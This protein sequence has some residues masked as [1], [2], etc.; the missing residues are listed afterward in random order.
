MEIFAYNDNNYYVNF[1]NDLLK[2]IKTL[3]GQ[4]LSSELITPVGSL[5]MGPIPEANCPD[6]YL[7]CNG[8]DV[9]RTKYAELFSLLGTNFGVGDGSTTFNIPDYR[10]CFL[11]MFSTDTNENTNMY[12][13]QNSG[14]PNI[15]GTFNGGSLGNG[16]STSGAFFLLGTATGSGY[17][18]LQA[19][20]RVGVFNASRSSSVYQDNIT[21]A[22]P[23]NYSI[24]YFIKY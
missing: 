9:S 6:G 16:D 20:D 21:E 22:R 17:A 4:T 2:V 13:K 14:V 19:Q 24:N 10:G 7:I 18:N 11:R 8:Q 3:S 15:T 12:A 1:S 5:I 23:T